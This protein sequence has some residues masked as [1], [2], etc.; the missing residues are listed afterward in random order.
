MTTKFT[1]A[2]REALSAQL[3]KQQVFEDS[4]ATPEQL[5]EAL[6]IIKNQ[7]PLQEHFKDIPSFE[8]AFNKEFA[9]ELAKVKALG[10]KAE[11]IVKKT[12]KKTAPK[13]AS[14]KVSKPVDKPAASPVDKHNQALRT[15]ASTKDFDQL[16]D[17]VKK[18]KYNLQRRNTD[19]KLK[20]VEYFTSKRDAN[21][22]V[23]KFEVIGEEERTVVARVS[24]ISR[25]IEV[26]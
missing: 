21:E 7:K 26:V 1:D 2:A 8:E 3:S 20:F 5:A 9:D 18:G 22:Q 14:A 19:Y 23:A 16:M 13:K 17:D 4:K 24:K 6:V 12:L 10:E 11:Q 15:V 25:F